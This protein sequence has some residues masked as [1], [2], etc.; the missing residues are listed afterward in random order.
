MSKIIIILLSLC[1]CLVV[2]C[3]FTNTETFTIDSNTSYLIWNKKDNSG[4]IPNKII[5]DNTSI[6]ILTPKM[7]TNSYLKIPNK[8][9][10]DDI[11]PHY[12]KYTEGPKQ[13]LK[14]F[15]D[16]KNIHLLC[17]EL[18]INYIAYNIQFK[19]CY[20]NTNTIVSNNKYYLSSSCG[21]EVKNI[22]KNI[23]KNSISIKK[24][25]YLCGKWSGEYWHFL[26]EYLTSM[27][28]VKHYEHYTIIVGS[29]SKFIMEFLEILNIP[30]KNIVTGD[31]YT[32]ELMVP[33]PQNCGNASNYSLHLLRETFIKKL[34]INY[35]SNDKFVILIKRNNSRQ[36]TNYKELERSIL[37]YYNK[38]NI[39]VF[40]HDDNN[41][42]SI[43]EQLLYFS[44]A[45]TIIAPHG[46]GL[47]NMFIS[48]PN[49]NIVE[50]FTQNNLNICYLCTSI[51]LGFN[52]FCTYSSDS[53]VN[54]NKI[55]TI[56]D[57]L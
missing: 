30:N 52:Y 44:K 16:N 47:S 28:N 38:K 17:K 18:Y 45:T 2:W 8:I 49:T 20:F 54:I 34:N 43:K 31:G 5:T 4:L 9:N 35:S 23:N 10:I 37:Q 57:T 53:K 6:T 13:N 33:N 56:L 32:D 15:I 48:N 11:Y 40:I 46:A 51:R 7:N 3:I 39:K 27:L 25:I 22:N 29:K 12:T 41:L 50:M 1:I 14:L 24:G 42:P 21:L 26:M 36:L 19:K 55:I